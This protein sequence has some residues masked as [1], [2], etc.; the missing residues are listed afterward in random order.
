[1][2]CPDCLAEI[3]LSGV[4]PGGETTCGCGT[5]VRVPRSGAQPASTQAAYRT[6]AVRK[7]AVEDRTGGPERARLADSSL[8]CPSCAGALRQ[9]TANGFALSTCSS[10]HGLFVEP[11]VLE[12]MLRYAPSLVA[13]GDSAPNGAA[14]VSSPVRYVRCPACAEIM[15][16]R[17]FA[18]SS[19]II[20]DVC[21]HGTWF[22][23]GELTQALAFAA[24]GRMPGGPSLG[25]RSN[26]AAG[27]SQA[28]A[29]RAGAPQAPAMQ[30]GSEA[31][32]A[33]PALELGTGLF[34]FFVRA[35]TY[36]ADRW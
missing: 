7:E 14:L 34:E 22:D 1:M 11:E 13:E 18:G 19:G 9:H 12:A 15:D 35:L 24:A 2:K 30:A 27:G 23:A 10:G 20:V 17:L 5:L 32:H 31:H 29:G 4:F 28:R 21:E 3:D 26:P 36:R 25:A 8:R 16:R 6:A 33:A